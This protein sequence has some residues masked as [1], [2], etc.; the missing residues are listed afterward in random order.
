[1]IDKEKGIPI[2]I[3][4]Q[5]ILEQ[6]LSEGILNVGE[7]VPSEYEFA[8]ELGVSRLTVRKAY[9]E[10]VKRNIFYAIQGSGT[11]VR[12][13]YIIP[14]KERNTNGKDDSKVI[15]V[16]FPEVTL[17]FTEII[18]AIKE[19]AAQYGYIINLMFNDTLENESQ[20]INNMINNNVDGVI[21]TPFRMNSTVVENHQRL[22]SEGIPLVMVGKPPFK[23]GCDSVY[24]DDVFASYKCVERF[25][26]NEHKRIAFITNSKGDEEA[27][28]ERREGYIRALKDY[29]P[30]FQPIIIDVAKENSNYKLE[31]SITGDNPVTAFFCI[32]DDV[33]QEVYYAVKKVG[34]KVPEELEIMGF[35][36]NSI[37]NSTLGIKLSSI[38][39]LRTQMGYYAF[40]VIKNRIEENKSEIKNN[41]NNHII[42]Q[43]EI[44]WR[45]TTRR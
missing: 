26:E 12:E 7:N 11:F 30:D 9:N 13:D 1:M 22:L 29:M 38:K 44:M 8:E 31:S 3:Q 27:M 20:A 32:G 10:M 35:D 42:I 5:E 2:Y 14:V 39:Q 41:Y 21:I 23:I 18:S 15:G 45:D 37:L 43:P 17:F 6:M 33:A 16:I 40:E 25:I 24:S 4:I 36:D 19:K 34:R 28:I